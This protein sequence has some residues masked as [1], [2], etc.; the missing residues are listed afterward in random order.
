[1]LAFEDK[2]KTAA[3]DTPSTLRRLLNDPKR[4]DALKTK[5]ED[6][7]D[8]YLVNDLC[9]DPETIYNS[10]PEPHQNLID[11]MIDEVKQ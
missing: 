6:S 3:V 2:E 10:L 1:M 11:N 4:K 9:Q 5:L 7:F 8:K